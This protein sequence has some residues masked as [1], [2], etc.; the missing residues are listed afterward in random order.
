MEN[1]DVF[2]KHRVIT[3][4]FEGDYYY[5]II[6]LQYRIRQNFRGFRGSSPNRKY[7]LRRIIN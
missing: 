4:H 6:I 3:K 2:P 1:I 5:C 7:V